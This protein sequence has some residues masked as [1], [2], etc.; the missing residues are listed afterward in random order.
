MT[1]PEARSAASVD[2]ALVARFK[3]A[4]ERLWP[5]AGKLGLAISGGPDSM[6][7]LLLAQAAIPS[8]FEVATVDHGLR[9]G[10]DEEC[11]T[12]ARLC[13]E[14]GIPCE[15]LPVTVRAGNLQAEA[16]AA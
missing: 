11:A 10:S 5:E 9:A 16:R 3:E 6:A 7:M 13:T 4:L 12:V 1:A 2:A 8:R 14:Q 15:V